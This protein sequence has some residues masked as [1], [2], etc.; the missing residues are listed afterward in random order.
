SAAWSQAEGT[1]R[2]GGTSV[3]RSRGRPGVRGR[4]GPV[5]PQTLHLSDSSRRAFDTDAERP[6]R[7]HVWRAA[8][9]EAPLVLLSHGTGGAADDLAWWVAG[10]HDAGFD[11]AAVD[12]HGN[13][14]HD[15]YL[16]EGFAW[17]W[18]R[19]RDLSFVLDHL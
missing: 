12:H 2:R 6:V 13:N 1:C 10:L 18:E 3:D 5:T 8:V 15:G 16:A 7:V 19:P 4:I 14:H 11:V 9:P 17:W